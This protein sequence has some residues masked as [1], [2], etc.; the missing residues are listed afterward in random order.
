MAKAPLGVVVQPDGPRTSRPLG[1]WNDEW[2]TKYQG[3]TPIARL[4]GIRKQT[5][6]HLQRYENQNLETQAA[7]I[8]GRRPVLPGYEARNRHYQEAIKARDTLHASH[9]MLSLQVRDRIE[10]LKPFDR[11]ASTYEMQLQAEY[12]SIFRSADAKQRN[13]LLK[14]FEFR[15]AILADGVVPEFVGLSKSTFD[16]LKEQ[17]LRERFPDDMQMADDFKIAD[18]MVGN[19]LSALDMQLETERRDLGISPLG[20]KAKP[21]PD[22]WE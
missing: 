19:H 11:P 6:P 21:T 1:A 20:A 7:T 8:A 18:E 14:S 10:G 3:E 13:E 16:H 2:T 17:R 15:Q 22:A 4:N 5:L 12:R 9:N